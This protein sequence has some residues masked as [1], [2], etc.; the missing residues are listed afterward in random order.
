MSLADEEFVLAALFHDIG[1][2]LGLEAFLEMEMDNCGILDHETIGAQFLYSLGFSYH[3]CQLVRNHVQ[4]KR[5]LCYKNPDY[6]NELSEAS[7][8]TLRFQG[9]PM[10]AEEG[11]AFEKH[12]M[13]EEILLLR[14][15]P[16]W[17][18]IKV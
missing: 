8:T 14:N 13:F 5:Y 17:K 4:A 16:K 12:P 15:R 6:Y 7:K 11:R 3:C 1:H 18:R 2:I 9:G 10:S